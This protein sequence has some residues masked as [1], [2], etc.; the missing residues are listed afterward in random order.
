MQKR[1]KEVREG[2]LTGT[3]ILQMY[4]CVD[5]Y[6]E[7]KRKQCFIHARVSVRVRVTL[8]HPFLLLLS[9]HWLT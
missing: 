7:E 3:S 1:S 8:G 2:I 9:L 4:M 6:T 5:V